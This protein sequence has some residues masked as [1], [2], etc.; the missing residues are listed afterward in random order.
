MDFISEVNDFYLLPLQ[1]CE[2]LLDSVQ[3]CNGDAVPENT[4]RARPSSDP[5]VTFLNRQVLLVPPPNFT[6]H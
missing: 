3:D 2:H 5:W 4:E 6:K 1:D